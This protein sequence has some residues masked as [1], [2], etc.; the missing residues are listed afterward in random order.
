M[1]EQIL[2][3]KQK[4]DLALKILKRLEKTTDSG[5]DYDYSICYGYRAALE[6]LGL[7]EEENRPL[8]QQPE[9]GQ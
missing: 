8:W 3:D 5:C 6:D 4:L 9:Q 7:I 2:V 1:N